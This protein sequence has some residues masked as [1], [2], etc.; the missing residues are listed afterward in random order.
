[1]SERGPSFPSFEGGSGAE[2]Q[3]GTKNLTEEVEHIYKFARTESQRE[4]ARKILEMMY[5]KERAK[6]MV[7]YITTADPKDISTYLDIKK[8]GI[9]LV[10][11]TVSSQDYDLGKVK[12]K[13]G[14]RIIQLH[15]PPRNEPA[16]SSGRLLADL[17]E[18]MQLTADYIRLHGLSP[19]FITGCTYDP[20]VS[21]AE[22]RYGF[23]AERLNIPDEMASRVEA[24]FRRHVDPEVKPN[25]GFIYTSAEA[26]QNRFP[27][28]V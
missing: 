20:L 14:D 15:I 1:M 10:H 3:R 24:V 28:K 12:I 27:Q 2:F 21:V 6:A 26:F 25:I 16:E 9:L 18:S 8:I 7:R 22:R 11:D 5:A 23:Q 13:K 17:T 4:F 19:E